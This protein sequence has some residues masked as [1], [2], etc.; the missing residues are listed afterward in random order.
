MTTPSNHRAHANRLAK[1]PSPYL[2]QH[3]Y[4]PVD[5]Y[6]WGE[7]AFARASEILGMDIKG[8]RVDIIWVE[9]ASDICSEG[10]EIEVKVLAIEGNKIRLSRK[11][12]LEVYAA[13]RDYHWMMGMVE[14][15]FVAVANAVA[16]ALE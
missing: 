5:W 10:D 11:A 9:H 13:Y 14:R 4:N 3:A 8:H 2:L 7:E 15:M 16:A 1:E 6:P 12:L